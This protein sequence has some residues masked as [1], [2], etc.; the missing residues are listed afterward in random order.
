MRIRPNPRIAIHGD[1]GTAEFME[2]YR[3]AIG[4]VKKASI[5]PTS[6]SLTWLIAQ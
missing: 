1:Y 2:I 3:A 5:S 4:G 6:H